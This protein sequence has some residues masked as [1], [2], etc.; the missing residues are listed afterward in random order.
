MEN[1]QNEFQVASQ[2]RCQLIN[3]TDRVEEVI[4]EADIKDGQV[5]VFV[6]HS[7]AAILL[8]ENEEGLKR[9]WL[10]VLKKIVSGFNFQHDQ[11]NETPSHF[12]PH[13]VSQDSAIDNNA[14]SHILSGLVGQGKTL[15]VQNGRI[16]RGTWQQIFL[17]EFDGPKTR[18]VIIKIS[19]N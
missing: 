6:P 7:T 5:L 16:V 13:P 10:D 11:I 3:I 17:A 9:D 18:K 14:D 12:S 15:P 1:K 8:T 2:E 19:G 4:K